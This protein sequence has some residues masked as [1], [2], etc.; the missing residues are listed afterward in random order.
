MT[1]R[2][3]YLL[4]L[5]LVSL[6]LILGRLFQFSIGTPCFFE[7]SIIGSTSF[8]FWIFIAKWIKTWSQKWNIFSS[9]GNVLIHGGLSL[10]SALINIVL[11]QALVIFLLTSLYQCESP[12]FE[13]INASMTNNI[14]TNLLCYF[15]LVG[16]FFYRPTLDQEKETSIKVPEADRKYLDLYKNGNKVKLPL[17]QIL[18]VEASNNCIIIHSQNEK[19][20]KYQSL[21]SLAEDYG[22]Q[23][24]RT[25]RSY[26]VNPAFIERVTKNKNGD[27]TIFLQ[28]GKTIKLSR[29][30]SLE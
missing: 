9:T 22:H 27:G 23:L 7:L 16:Y 18:Y 28:N 1:I 12:S 2:F 3:H 21:K 26:L 30:Y 8:L 29:S 25:H 24:K 19:F 10:S 4:I 17:E 13:F 6:N 20:V 15:V 11:G 5:G 14:A